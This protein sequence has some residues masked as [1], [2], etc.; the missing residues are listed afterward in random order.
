MEQN[1]QLSTSQSDPFEDACREIEWP[2]GTTFNSAIDLHPSGESFCNRVRQAINF[3]PK[4]G[5]LLVWIDIETTGLNPVKNH[6]LEIALAVTARDG[7][8]IAELAGQDKFHSLIFPQNIEQVADDYTCLGAVYEIDNIWCNI[9]SNNGLFMDHLTQK[10]YS[11]DFSCAQVEKRIC[12]WL[13][14][15]KRK[16]NITQPLVAAGINVAFDLG[17][18]AEKMPILKNMLHFSVLEMSTLR[19]ISKSKPNYSAIPKELSHRALYDVVSAIVE[20]TGF[21]LKY[22]IQG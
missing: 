8:P 9:F 14:A 22:D 6:M 13:A 19:I 21:C 15:L 18:I 3:T 12:E 10:K 4:W 17:F 2:K 11:S 16:L 5:N 20:Y 7:K 1:Q